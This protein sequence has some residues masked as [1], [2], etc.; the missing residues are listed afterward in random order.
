M[1]QEMFN[2]SASQF[3]FRLPKKI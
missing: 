2:K 3:D 1:H